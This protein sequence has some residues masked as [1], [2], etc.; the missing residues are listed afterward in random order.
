MRVM[1]VAVKGGNGFA[2]LVELG[3]VDLLLA[4]AGQVHLH[5]DTLLLPPRKRGENIFLEIHLMIR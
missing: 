3:G 5:P 1:V 4:A 2:V